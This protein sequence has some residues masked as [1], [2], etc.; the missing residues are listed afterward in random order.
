MVFLLRNL[1]QALVFALPLILW[2]QPSEEARKNY[3][4]RIQKAFELQS[5]GKTRLAFYTFRDAYQAAIKSGESPAKL[6]PLEELFVWYRTYG[7][8]SGVMKDPA[9]CAGEYRSSTG[10]V[11]LKKL[12][13]Q[14]QKIIRD[15]LY[16][17]GCIVSGVFCLTV[18]TPLSGKFGTTL[19]MGGCN[20]MYNSISAMIED[21]EK[22]I[23]RI[24]ELDRITRKVIATTKGEK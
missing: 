8:D 7:F 16:G 22:R 21:H 5:Q 3:S 24:A 1:V 23:A 12:D 2:A 18:S 19:V 11:Q 10:Y 15:F 14:Q 13:P 17:V 9:A 4:D 6:A 20:Y